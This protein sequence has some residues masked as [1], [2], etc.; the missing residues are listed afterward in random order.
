M[1]HTHCG[2]RRLALCTTQAA[3]SAK[4]LGEYQTLLTNFFNF[5][6]NSAVRYNKL[7]EIHS[8]LQLKSVTLRVAA[9]NRWLSL[10]NAVDAIYRCCPALVDCLDQQAAEGNND[11]S[12]KS[13]GYL[14]QVQQ[15]KFVAAT[16]M[17][18]DVLP[19]LTKLSVF[20]QRICWSCI[21]AT[22]GITYNLHI[23]DP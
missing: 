22:Y 23:A 10:H 20:F 14:K 9:S 18:K 2:A 1:V 4:L 15:Y 19:T 16:C 6:S 11:S 8:I 13:K 7:S 12:A 5:Y 17:M 21:C 3:K